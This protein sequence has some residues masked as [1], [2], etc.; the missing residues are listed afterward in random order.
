VV[1]FGVNAVINKELDNKRVPRSTD[2][3]KINA[4][5]IGPILNEQ[6]NQFEVPIPHR[7]LQHPIA[8][9]LIHSL[10]EQEFY[11]AVEPGT[12][13]KNESS[14]HLTREELYEAV[15]SKATR[16]VAQE[17]GIS[18][19][20][21]AK[22]CRKLNVPKPGLG[23]WRKIETGSKLK[24]P[25]LPAHGLAFVK[26]NPARH[27][28][29]RLLPNGS[30][31]TATS[32]EDPA[33]LIPKSL[34][35]A[36]PAILKAKEWIHRGVRMDSFGLNAYSDTPVIPVRVEQSSSDRAF[37]FLAGLLNGLSQKGIGLVRHHQTRV[38]GFG[39]NEDSLHFTLS[40]H[41]PRHKTSSQP[42]QR[43]L[44]FE[45]D[46][47]NFDGS[48]RTWTDGKR[49]Q[50]EDKLEEIVEWISAGVEAVR[51]RRLTAEA[52]EKKRREKERE[53]AE[54]EREKA[55]EEKCRTNLI[56]QAEMWNRATLLRGFINACEKEMT[57]L[58]N[59][60]SGAIKWLEWARAHAERIDPL[61]NGVL[62]SEFDR[63]DGRRV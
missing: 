12:R 53:L 7:G 28:P 23:Y 57:S 18:D 62:H 47:C 5:G 58:G 33:H 32:S 34:D 61:K 15:W 2:S 50:I 38:L 36:H 59:K 37:K 8:V 40:D 21:L 48:E 51:N 29:K 3:G 6:L 41:T 22:I 43:I 25:P 9:R 4:G 45:L 30:V 1:G 44:K 17:L 20:A 56:D 14:T 49:Y 16:L 26:I 42:V 46:R 11:H 13:L 52:E 39:V 10:L 31:P 55:A 63:F 19:V 35:G 27:A 60:N 24:R 54:I